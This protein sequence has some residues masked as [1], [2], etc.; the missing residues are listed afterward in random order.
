MKEQEINTKYLERSVTDVESRDG[1]ERA[2]KR[3]FDNLLAAE[4]FPL[5]HYTQPSTAARAMIQGLVSIAISKES[6]RHIRSGNNWQGERQISL[7][8]IEGYIQ[9]QG[10]EE[11][12]EEI[13]REVLG[14]G[15][16][17]VRPA[18]FW[19]TGGVCL[20]I[21]PALE[22][23]YGGKT[24][25]PRDQVRENLLGIGMQ[26]EQVRYGGGYS[27]EAVVPDK[28]SSEDIYGVVLTAQF[29]DTDLGDAFKKKVD[30]LEAKV[31]ND[32]FHKFNDEINLLELFGV[33]DEDA[34]K[35]I[36]RMRTEYEKAAKL[37]ATL[38][39]PDSFTN[40]IRR[41]A[42]EMVTPDMVELENRQK[43]DLEAILAD[44]DLQQIAANL[45]ESSQGLITKL[46][47]EGIS[48]Y[49]ELIMFLAKSQGVPVYNKNS[50]VV[51]PNRVTN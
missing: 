2:E 4:P 20:L 27:G 47:S 48:T 11:R 1:R 40:M 5:I 22:R 42:P 28:I 49:S 3:V 33:L 45:V 41:D 29:K 38:Y 14:M 36:E 23:F 21:N 17:D 6:G 18:G 15:M 8:D 37:H 26:G 50:E 43:K 16:P 51:W 30:S 7:T 31:P 32:Y 39:A 44:T 46:R 35:G 25:V 13:A 12:R 9:E 34:L 24:H 19:N 10:T